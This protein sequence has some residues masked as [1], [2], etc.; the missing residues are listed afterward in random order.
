MLGLV[1]VARLASLAFAT[2]ALAAACGSSGGGAG[3]TAAADLDRGKK[4]FVASCGSCH[5][6]K[7]AGTKGI[8]GGP[9]DGLALG[10][11]T[12]EDRVRHGGDG[13]PSFADALSA[14]DIASVSAF[15]A[16]ASKR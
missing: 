9:L 2:A 3:S 7:A 4:V 10:A 8:V 12:V 6:L 5:S 16:A 14:H 13:M 1:I 15:V 11:S